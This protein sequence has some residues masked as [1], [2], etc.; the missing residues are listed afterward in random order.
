MDIGSFLLGALVVVLV[1]VVLDL[2]IAGG[3]MSAGMMGGMAGAMGTPWG[4]G[5]LALL[6]LVVFI[7]FA[8][9]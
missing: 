2:L 4:W 1:L 8:A 7:A 5:V 9:H 3:G 6:A